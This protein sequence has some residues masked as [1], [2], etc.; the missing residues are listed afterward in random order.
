MKLLLNPVPPYGKTIQQLGNLDAYVVPTRIYGAD[1]WFTTLAEA[2]A[3]AVEWYESE[4]NC[5]KRECD[6]KRFARKTLDILRAFPVAPKKEAPHD[7]PRSPRG[8]ETPDP[9]PGAP[10]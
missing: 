8:G 5:Y 2:H 6:G 9:R 7:L 1:P 3:G 10:T 4:V